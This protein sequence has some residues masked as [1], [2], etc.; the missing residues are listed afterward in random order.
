MVLI[1]VNQS[2]VRGAFSYTE[3][4]PAV[5]GG[6]YSNHLTFDIPS[7]KRSTSLAGLCSGMMAD[8]RRHL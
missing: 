5:D 6:K 4:T 2:Y 8:A 7:A 3:I 1:Y